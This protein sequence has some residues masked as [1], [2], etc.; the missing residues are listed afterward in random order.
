MCVCNDVN[1][2]YMVYNYYII[3]CLFVSMCS[4]G[5]DFKVSG[6]AFQWNDGLFGMALAPTGDGYSTLY[7]HPLS[8]GMEFSVNT[9]FLRDQQRAGTAGMFNLLEYI[10][11]RRHTYIILLLSRA[12]IQATCPLLYGNGYFEQR[13]PS[14][15]IMALKYTHP[16]L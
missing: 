8:S 11:W 10:Y 6:I 7:Y 16:T 13:I 1:P 2:R 4:Q 9:R 12:I 5:G 14:C 3:V 15:D